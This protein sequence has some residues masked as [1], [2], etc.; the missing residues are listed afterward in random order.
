MVQGHQNDSE[1]SD[2]S[3]A[4]VVE[5]ALELGTAIEVLEGNQEAKL[6][7]ELQPTV[8]PVKSTSRSR[9]TA[10]SAS[11]SASVKPVEPESTKFS[12]RA[13]KRVKMEKTLSCDPSMDST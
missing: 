8:S 6:K 11:T 2:L 9:N 13:P 3:R 10:F 5:T 7:R 4:H 12:S 1:I